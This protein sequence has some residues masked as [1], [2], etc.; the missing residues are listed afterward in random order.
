MNIS[1]HFKGGTQLVQIVLKGSV[2][3]GYVDGRGGRES[4]WRKNIAAKTLRVVAVRRKGLKY[5]QRGSQGQREGVI[6]R[7]W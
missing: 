1:G 6:Q 3:R 5:N 2:C 7:A 4:E